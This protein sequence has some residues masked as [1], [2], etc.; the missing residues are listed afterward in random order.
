MLRALQQAVV[1]DAEAANL[2][3]QL[4]NCGSL[5]R[6]KWFRLGLRIAA[7]VEVGQILLMARRHH[8]TQWQDQQDGDGSN[9]D[10]FPMEMHSVTT[11][12]V[13]VASIIAQP[14]PDANACVNG[15]E[16]VINRSVL[17]AIN[18]NGTGTRRAPP[19]HRAATRQ[20]GPGP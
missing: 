1:L 10:C 15:F 6:G 12:R 13:Q 4:L 3:A 7:F 5:R 2:A 18:P 8:G 17:R 19:I 9:G 16:S 20:A 14:G 11:R